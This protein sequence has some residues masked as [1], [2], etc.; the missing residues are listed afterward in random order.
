MDE[1]SEFFPSKDLRKMEVYANHMY[2]EYAK[3]Y[4]VSNVIASVYF[5]QLLN[6]G[7]F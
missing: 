4:Y 6:D 7:D 1:E 5:S 3:L 2:E